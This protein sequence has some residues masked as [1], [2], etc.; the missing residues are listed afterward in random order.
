MTRDPV[1][2]GKRTL[3]GVGAALAAGIGLAAAASETG[4]DS[5]TEAL[6]RTLNRQLLYIA[7]PTTLLLEGILLYTV[8]R[9]RDAEEA[10]P[11]T[12]N[13]R[14]E[15]AWLLVVALV[16][17][18]VGLS[19][20]QTLVSMAAGPPP[21]TAAAGPA[22]P[23]EVT[24]TGQQFSWEFEYSNADVTTRETLVLPVNRTIVLRIVSADVIHSVHVPSL[25]IKRDAIPGQVNHVR[26]RITDRGTYRLYCA[27]YCG[28]GHSKMLAT[29]RVVSPEAYQRWLHNQRSNESAVESPRRER[30]TDA[31]TGLQRDLDSLRPGFFGIEDS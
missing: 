26:T 2:S 31:E 6:I 7:I 16:L 11:T 20:Y 24:V 28:E 19:S 1:P 8:M 14:L 17:L 10:K 15:V 21:R 25:G 3:I 29:V 22:D 18:F 9:F 27:E 5:T 23:V 4:Y 13:P 12:E 30:P